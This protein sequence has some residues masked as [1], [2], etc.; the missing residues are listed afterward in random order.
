MGG[1]SGGGPCCGG[2]SGRTCGSGCAGSGEGASASAPGPAG[3]SGCAAREACDGCDGRAGC[4]GCDGCAV[5]G[6]RACATGAS[7]PAVG[8]AGSVHGVPPSGTAGVDCAVCDGWVCCAGRARCGRRVWGVGADAPPHGL[9]YPVGSPASGCASRT[10]CTA[11]STRAMAGVM[12]PEGGVSAAGGTFHAPGP[13]SRTADPRV[14]AA[15]LSAPMDIPPQGE[16]SKTSSITADFRGAGEGVLLG[17]TTIL[18][19]AGLRGRA[20]FGSGVAGVF[21]CGRT[22][23]RGRAGCEAKKEKMSGFSVLA[24]DFFAE[25]FFG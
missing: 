7:A 23:L 4:A 18:G 25:S 13:V 10:A 15:G 3:C 20:T 1:S 6:G 17:W 11:R 12:P 9:K 16:T 14:A 21:A 24:T 5:P 19:I 2:R 22:G 8:V